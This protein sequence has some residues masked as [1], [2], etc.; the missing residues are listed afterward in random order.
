MRILQ[1]YFSLLFT[2]LQSYLYIKEPS[3][4]KI[5]SLYILIP[6]VTTAIPPIIPIIIVIAAPYSSIISSMPVSFLNL[7]IFIQFILIN[8]CHIISQYLCQYVNECV[9]YHYNYRYRHH[10]CSIFFYYSFHS[11]PIPQAF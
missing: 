7:I 1:L 5:I 4:L 11:A 9:Y 3:I 10:Y 8:I 2:L 6:P